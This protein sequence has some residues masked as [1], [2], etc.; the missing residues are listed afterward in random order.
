M[1]QSNNSEGYISSEGGKKGGYWG[2]IM[3]GN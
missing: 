3:E 1:S 2:G